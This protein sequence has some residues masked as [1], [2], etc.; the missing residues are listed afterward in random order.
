[1]SNFSASPFLRPS[2]S[3]T[4]LASFSRDPSA[5]LT[6]IPTPARRVL[7]PSLPRR[8]LDASP[9]HDASRFGYTAFRDKKLHETSRSQEQFSSFRTPERPPATTHRPRGIS[10]HEH[11]DEDRI[12]R[13]PAKDRNDEWLASLGFDLELL[14]LSARR[15]TRREKAA[16]ENRDPNIVEDYQMSPPKYTPKRTPLRISMLKRTPSAAEQQER[17]PLAM[18]SDIPTFDLQESAPCVAPI[19]E[20]AADSSTLIEERG[21]HTSDKSFRAEQEKVHRSDAT[22]SVYDFSEGRYPPAHTT[23]EEKSV[24][25]FSEDSAS[26]SNVSTGEVTLS[27]PPQQRRPAALSSAVYGTANEAVFRTPAARPPSGMRDSRIIRSAVALKGRT[28]SYLDTSS[29]AGSTTT[30][31]TLTPARIRSAKKSRR[32]SARISAREL[33]ALAE[34]HESMGIEAEIAREA[35]P[36]STRRTRSRRSIEVTPSAGHVVERGHGKFATA[37]FVLSP[38]RPTKQ[39]KEALG[40]ESIVTPVRRSMRIS[41]RHVPMMKIDNVKE[42]N[43]EKLESANYAFLPNQ[44]LPEIVSVEKKQNL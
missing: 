19:S 15:G 14:K 8:P 32:A 26:H 44:N 17:A 10:H 23:L 38:V 34:G 41:M 6:R 20:A 3:Q 25:S 7:T 35:T 42:H 21:N 18:R 31:T 5:T 9:I 12:S 22:F 27:T 30:E 24:F 16:E 40:S 1:M 36:M 11:F 39:Q 4:N 2:N 33:R 13:T 29:T 37:N 28:N 43:A